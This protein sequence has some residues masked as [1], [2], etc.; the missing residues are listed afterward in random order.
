MKARNI[1][2]AMFAVSSTFSAAG[3]LRQVSKARQTRDALL[4][5][6]ALANAAVVVTG[7]ALAIRAFRN[8][9]AS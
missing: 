9:G 5:V 3:A 8:K 7:I 6:N 4:L 1:R 2:G